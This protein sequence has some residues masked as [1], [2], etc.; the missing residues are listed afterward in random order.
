[1]F[2]LKKPN[3]NEHLLQPQNPCSCCSHSPLPFRA[4]PVESSVSFPMPPTPD[5]AYP[6]LDST[7]TAQ[8]LSFSIEVINYLHVVKPCRLLSELILCDQ[9]PTLLAIIYLLKH[10]L[11]LVSMTTN[12]P[13][14][15]P[16]SLA[17]VSQSHWSV[18]TLTQSLNAG[19]L[20][21]LDFRPS[22]L[23]SYSFLSLDF[24]RCSYPFPGV[25]IHSSSFVYHPL[26]DDS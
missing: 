15:L 22:S 4:K 2:Q 5:T 10:F 6:N 18:T 25:L 16:F 8:G 1:M 12:L 11:T 3:Q 17:I 21:G 24:F 9:H 20:S 26:A 23:Q 13:G 7:R 14:F 19:I